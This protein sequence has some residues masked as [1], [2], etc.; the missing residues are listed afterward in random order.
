M[1]S[2]RLVACTFRGG[3]WRSTKD[4]LPKVTRKHATIGATVQRSSQGHFS[5]RYTLTKTAPR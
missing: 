1:P 2:P 5:C 3:S 4:H